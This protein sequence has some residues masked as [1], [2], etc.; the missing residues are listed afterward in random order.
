VVETLFN[1]KSNDAVRV[2]DEI[3]SFGILVSDHSTRESARQSQ[4]QLHIT[5]VRRAMSWGV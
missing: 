5:H 4:K 3:C 2:E 1:E